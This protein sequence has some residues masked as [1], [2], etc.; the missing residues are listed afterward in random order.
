MS[1]SNKRSI[2]F[3]LLLA[4]IPLWLVASGI[5][6]MWYYFHR[7]KTD[8]LIEQA[9]F[10]QA[11]SATLM[12]D[13]LRKIV[14]VI[15]ERNNSSKQ[16]AANLSRTSAM[17][18][19]LL[20]PSNTGYTVKTHKGPAN[21]PLLQVTVT[22]KKPDAPALW[23]VTSYDSCVGSRGVE[24]NATGLAATLA[25]AQSLASDKPECNIQFIFLPHVNDTDSQVRETALELTQLVTEAGG[26]KSILC[27]ESMGAGKTLWLSS[28]DTTAAPLNLIYKLGKVHG[29]DDICLGDDTD[30]TSTLFEMNLP[31]VRVST[32][33]HV[34]ESEPDDKLPASGTLAASTGR[35]IELIHR[36]LKPV[37]NS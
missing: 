12:N 31:A 26:A 37:K 21:W 30:L 34:A 18:E 17:I 2:L 10:P 32:R 16:A 6:A 14:D 5:G 8:A 36:C 11:V 19:G 4:L 22:G 9:R 13:D 23:V 3:P 20:G 1:T 24:A 35:L 15:G 7:E 27:V 28:R 29:A 25:A 33:A